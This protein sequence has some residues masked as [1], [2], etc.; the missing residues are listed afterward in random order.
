MRAALEAAGFP[1]YYLDE[2]QYQFYLPACANPGGEWVLA[3]DVSDMSRQCGASAGLTAAECAYIAL[4][5][6]LLTLLWYANNWL[7]LARRACRFVVLGIWP[8]AQA[9]GHEVHEDEGDDGDDSHDDD[10]DGYD[11][12]DD[13]VV[14]DVDDDDDDCKR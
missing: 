12:H 14:V 10:D 3:R 2:V 8:M 13:D 9:P 4:G 11:H 7:G 5:I 6:V 1:V